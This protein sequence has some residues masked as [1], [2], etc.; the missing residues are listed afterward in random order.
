VCPGIVEG[1]LQWVDANGF[2][3]LSED[4]APSI[5]CFARARP[6]TTEHFSNASALIFA[7]GGAL[8]HACSIA[9]ERG[10]PTVSGLGRT[11]AGAIQAWRKAGVRVHV[12]LNGG[13]GE[14]SCS[15]IAR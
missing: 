9:R 7:E 13:T 11:F 6:E 14:V 10:I 8:S 15:P 2:L 3:N 1:E 12:R 5:L 4:G